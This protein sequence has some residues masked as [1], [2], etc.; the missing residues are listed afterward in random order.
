MAAPRFKVYD[1]DGKYQAACKH[2]ED[3]ANLV[4]VYG[5]GATI[6]DGHGPIVWREGPNHD[7][8]GSDSYDGT[9]N[10][11]W[12]R[13]HANQLCNYTKTYGAAALKAALS[14]ELAAR[15]AVQREEEA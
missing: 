9:A 5:D 14:E 10:V 15:A 13:I 12:E 3:A 2:A 8:C 7:G 6:R 11:V 1:S 4:T